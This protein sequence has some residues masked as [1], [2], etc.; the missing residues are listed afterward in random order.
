MSAQVLPKAT[1]P[2]THITTGQDR[3]DIVAPLFSD[4]RHEEIVVAPRRRMERSRWARFA[5]ARALLM[6]GALL[7]VAV[8]VV[9]L[10]SG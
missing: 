8:L 4:W 5:S 2:M 7:G 3:L 6:L 10:L 9:V 1:Q